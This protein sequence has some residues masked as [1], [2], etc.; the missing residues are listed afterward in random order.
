MCRAHIVFALVPEELQSAL[1]IM[2]VV[3]YI[4]TTL[5]TSLPTKT[6]LHLY[7]PLAAR[8]TEF[9]QCWVS[10]KLRGV[11]IKQVGG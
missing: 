5:T 4:L 9:H 2:V 1:S 8:K 11:E 6:I 3:R 10:S 7:P